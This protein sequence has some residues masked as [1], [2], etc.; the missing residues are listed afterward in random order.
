MS[1]F[2]LAG[3]ARGGVGLDGT[4]WKLSGWTLNSLNPADFSITARFDRGKIS[5]MSGVN[6]Y[7]GRY[8]L[9]SHRAFAVGQLVSTE[10]AGPQPAMR[11][12]RAYLTLLRQAR[13]YKRAKDRLTLVDGGGNASLIFEAAGG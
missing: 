7:G 13:S 10:M 3:C 12:E 5:G 4:R 9:G 6:S 8:R 11:A 1:L 2:V